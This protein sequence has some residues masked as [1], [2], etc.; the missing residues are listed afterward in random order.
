MCRSKA[1]GGQRCYAHAVQTL[2][3]ADTRYAQVLE[4]FGPDS[5]TPRPG[6]VGEAARKLRGRQVELASTRRGYDEIRAAAAAARQRGDLPLADYYDRLAEEG[7]QMRA[8][9]AAVGRSGGN[10]GSVHDLAVARARRAD[11]PRSAVDTRGGD[12]PTRTVPGRTPTPA[13][14]PQGTP[15]SAGRLVE[16]LRDERD[17]A[18]AAV[19]AAQA[20]YA[21]TPTVA[22]WGACQDAVA[23]YRRA[24][25]AFLRALP[26]PGP[27]VDFTDVDVW[28]CPPG[29]GLCDRTTAWR[30][31]E[32]AARDRDTVA[33]RAGQMS[34]SQFYAGV[35]AR[36]QARQTVLDGEGDGAVDPVDTGRIPSLR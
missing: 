8:R 25:L 31:L 3:A 10:G 14:H 13:P 15:R 28:R 20:R 32:L 33:V 7:R 18:R 19:N 22:N 2:A 35:A 30:S 4:E 12:E 11:R 16:N 23:A 17:A 24:D 5:A 21:A 36:S 34:S 29:A 26:Q 9:N 6:R 27:G 1:E